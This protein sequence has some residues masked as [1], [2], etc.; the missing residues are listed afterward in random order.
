MK[1]NNKKVYNLIQSRFVDLDKKFV[2][3]NRSKGFTIV[4]MLVAM[5][6]FTV[7]ISIT[8]S[9]FIRSLRTQRY[10]NALLAANSNASLAM[11]QM[12]R[13]IRTGSKFCQ[14][15]GSVTD[16]GNI[17]NGAYEKLSF[18]SATRGTIT[19]ARDASSG[20]LTQT[21][22]GKEAPITASNV[23]VKKLSFYVQGNIL[24]DSQAARITIVLQISAPGTPFADS[25]INLQ[26]TVSSRNITNE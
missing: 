19:Y 17:I 12:A 24:N 10:A 22:Y 6:L 21:I 20:A 3:L 9:I 7:I 26:T 2:G 8:T 15:T 11:E 5:S 23:T 16:C 25:A 18:S 13:D 1:T 4:E 14:D